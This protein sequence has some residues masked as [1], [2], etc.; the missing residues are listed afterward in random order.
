M[1]Y[2]KV[3]AQLSYSIT[4]VSAQQRVLVIVHLHAAVKSILGVGG[5]TQYKLMSHITEA[6]VQLSGIL[7]LNGEG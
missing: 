6:N 7:I 5:Q 3:S 4:I 2:E 1:G